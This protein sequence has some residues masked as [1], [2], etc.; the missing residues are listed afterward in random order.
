MEAR[1]ESG[2][3]T[4][5]VAS[6]QVGNVSDIDVVTFFV[7]TDLAGA[8]FAEVTGGEGVVETFKRLI[9]DGDERVMKVSVRFPIALNPSIL[10]VFIRAALW[11]TE[12]P[13]SRTAYISVIPG[14]GAV[15]G[16]GVPDNIAEFAPNWSEGSTQSE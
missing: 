11:G 9:S 16:I 8:E 5:T 12:V 13:S 7:D 1:M 4:Q 15:V 3:E 10:S 6:G 2:E 14:E